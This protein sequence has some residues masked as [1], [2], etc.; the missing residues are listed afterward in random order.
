M[1][2]RLCNSYDFVRPHQSFWTYENLSLI[3]LSFYR[4][5]TSRISITSSVIHFVMLVGE[6]S[7]LKAI[8]FPYEEKEEEWRDSSNLLFTL[9]L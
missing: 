1:H 7:N 9:F 2:T 6:S 4:L 8:E 5:Y 3:C